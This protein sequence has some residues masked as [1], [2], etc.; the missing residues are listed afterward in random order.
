MHVRTRWKLF[1]RAK[2]WPTTYTVRLASPA[3]R[4]LD[5][6]PPR[7]A[8]ADPAVHLHG[9]AAGPAPGRQTLERELGYGAQRG[10]Y[11]VTYEFQKEDQRVLVVRVDQRPRLPVAVKGRTAPHL[12]SMLTD[13]I[14]TF[15]GSPRHRPD[16]CDLRR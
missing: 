12:D 1:Q 10:D 4:D 9:S 2:M 5:R 13:L 11:R 6:I 7:Y 8:G 16:N 3:L 14:A 15:R